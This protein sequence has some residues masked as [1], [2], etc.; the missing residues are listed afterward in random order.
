MPVCFVLIHQIPDEMPRRMN[1]PEYIAGFIQAKMMDLE[2]TRDFLDEFEQLTACELRRT[3]TQVQTN[4]RTI[5]E[6]MNALKGNVEWE[7]L[8]KRMAQYERDFNDTYKYV[9]RRIDAREA[10]ER[11]AP[12]EM[13]E[14]PKR[15]ASMLY[16]G[17]GNTLAMR[18]MASDESLL[19]TTDE[20]NTGRA[21]PP[22]EEDKR[23]RNPRKKKKLRK[24]DLDPY[25]TDED[26]PMPLE[27]MSIVYSQRPKLTKDDLRRRLNQMSANDR[28]QAPSVSLSATPAVVAM[29]RRVQTQH[30]EREDSPPRARSRSPQASSSGPSSSDCRNE[31][32]PSTSEAV[33]TH[34]VFTREM[35][36]QRSPPSA[37]V[38][39]SPP[40]QASLPNPSARQSYV[41]RQQFELPP[42]KYEGPTPRFMNACPTRIRQ[43]DP[44]IV[45]LTEF[46]IIRRINYHECPMCG[47]NHKL[48]YCEEFARRPLIWRWWFALS[49]GLCLYCL[50]MGHSHFTCWSTDEHGSN[51][52]PRCR[53]RHNSLL[54]RNSPANRK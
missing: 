5:H 49:N 42:G 52:C 23:V 53:I 44:S 50:T 26:G 18:Y 32:Q 4:N 21:T 17:L 40:R 41:V 15:D 33:R 47:S 6:Q 9:M 19:S 51:K 43:D 45:G 31:P 46:Y 48:I 38:Q 3:A 16:S 25:A 2:D 7:A 8:D 22:A 36:R 54:C 27:C 39:R 24:E 37:E 13:T 10:Y 20:E 34:R 12:V 1:T 14:E 28:N 30:R 29:T 35:L 11:A